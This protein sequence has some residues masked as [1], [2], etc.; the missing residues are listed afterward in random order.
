MTMDQGDRASSAMSSTIRT[1]ASE[2][3]EKGAETERPSFPRLS[4]KKAAGGKSELRRIRVPPHR[5]TALRESWESILTPLVKHMK[6]QVRMNTKSRAVE[7]RTSE[8]TE[9]IG[10]LQKGA[11]FVEAFMLGFEIA[12]AVALLRLDDLYVDTFEIK[13]VKSLHGD[14]LSREST[15]LHD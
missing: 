5:Y 6:L 12:D 7:M 10:A 13:D 3:V 11:D 1:I 15:S 2:A 9:D 4:A 14:H 8:H